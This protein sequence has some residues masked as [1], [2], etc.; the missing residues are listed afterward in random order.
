MP[1]TIMTEKELILRKN[2]ELG[3][4]LEASRALTSSFDLE[5]NLSSAMNTLGRMLDMQKGCVFLLEPASKELKIAAAYGLTAGE[6]KRGKCKMGEGIVGKVI[7]TGEPIFIPDIGHEGRFLDRT[8]SRPKKEGISF[9]SVPIRFKGETL[10]VLSADR[11]YAEEHGGVE[12]DL[13][14]LGIVA[15]L[16]AQFV[17]LHRAFRR[18]E[19]EKESLR[20]QLRDRFSTENIIGE[21]EK[22]RSVLK[23]VLKAAN[24]DATVLL[25]GESGTGKE[26]RSDIPL[27][28]NHYMDKFNAVYGKRVSLTEAAVGKLLSHDWPGNVRELANT[29]ERLVIM[30]EK[31]TADADDAFN[32]TTHCPYTPPV[33]SSSSLKEEV[34]AIESERIIRALKENNNVKHRAASALGITPRQLGYKIK[35]YRID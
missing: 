17:K 19:E 4:V 25:L 21:S 23:A 24:T 12:N 14:V 32:R 6:I 9:I 26:R 7:E 11:I 27:L 13:R 1:F 20:S 30:S 8:G 3:A 15:S 18:A 5:G 28:I 22:F 31:N 16:I 10:G 33:S 2:K 35:K 34:S 29:L